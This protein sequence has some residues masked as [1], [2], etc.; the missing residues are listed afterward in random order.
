MG[1]L[2]IDHS[3][4]Q[5]IDGR[6]GVKQEF[7]TA[8]CKHCGSVI[9][10]LCRPLGQKCY[11]SSTDVAAATAV[12][13]DLPDEYVGKRRCCRCRGNLCRACYA[14]QPACVTLTQRADII[15]GVLDRIRRG[16]PLDTIL[17]S[18]V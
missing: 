8:A 5:G 3:A 14:G 11:L 9:A 2:T 17:E 16:D 18:G 4:G 15:R 1:M 10:V 13:K 6:Q 12:A 7:D